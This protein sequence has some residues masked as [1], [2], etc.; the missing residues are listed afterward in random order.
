MPR[1]ITSL[2]VFFALLMGPLTQAQDSDLRNPT[3]LVDNSPYTGD[4]EGMVQRRIIRVLTVYGPG[5]YYLDNG[6][7]GITAEYANRLE[8]VINDSY[9]TGHLKVVVF[10]LPVARDELFVAL[11]QGRGDIIMAG[12][13]VTP[14]REQQAAFTY[15]PANR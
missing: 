5:R 6:A 8:K 9:E 1:F 10:V 7:K 11:E 2:M 13:T 14:A 3:A 12:T 15:R 4:L